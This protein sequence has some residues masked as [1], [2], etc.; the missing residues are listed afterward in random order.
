MLRGNSPDICTCQSESASYKWIKQY[1][2]IYIYIYH[3][4]SMGLPKLDGWFQGKSIYNMDGMIC[5]FLGTPHTYQWLVCII[6][7]FLPIYGEEVA[8]LPIQAWLNSSLV[9]KCVR[10]YCSRDQ[11][12]VRNSQ[13]T[14]SMANEGKSADTLVI[15]IPNDVGQSDSVWY[16]PINITTMKKTKM[17]MIKLMITM[18]M[19]MMTM[20][21]RMMMMMMMTMTMALMMLMKT[22]VVVVINSNIYIYTHQLSAATE[23]WDHCFLIYIYILNTNTYISK[24]KYSCIYMY[25]YIYIYTCVYI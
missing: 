14:N 6:S 5:L 16:L 23:H 10:S 7:L 4:I 9:S 22:I 8:T 1:V 18:M 2:Y 21:M 12:R 17:I 15:G 13:L 20:K 3:H 11:S 24:R 19:M 25:T